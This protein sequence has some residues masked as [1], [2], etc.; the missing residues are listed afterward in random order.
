M[1][2]RTLKT[3]KRIYLNQILQM[4]IDASRKL[5]IFRVYSYSKYRLMPI[6]LVLCR[7]FNQN[8]SYLL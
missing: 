1:I 6:F 2:C 8:K 5:G 3:L 7:I 4:Q